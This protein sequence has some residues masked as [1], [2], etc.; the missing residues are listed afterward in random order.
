MTDP[1]DRNPD[2]D[3]DM[4]DI[5]DVWY[6]QERELIDRAEAQKPSTDWYKLAAQTCLPSLIHTA[7]T[8]PRA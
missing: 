6:E 4:N 2:D 1:C 3:R 8:E 5:A 7:L